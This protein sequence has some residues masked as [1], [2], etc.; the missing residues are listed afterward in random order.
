MITV[1]GRVGESIKS[2]TTREDNSVLSMPAVQVGLVII[3]KGQGGE[4][5]ES[6]T[7]REDDTVL[8]LPPSW[9][10]NHYAHCIELRR[11]CY[12]QL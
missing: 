9:S 11:L 7:T 4:S 1:R 5:I 2:G 3:I 8:S 12:V 6:V 10:D